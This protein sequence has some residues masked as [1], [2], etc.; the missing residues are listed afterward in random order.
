MAEVP[1]PTLPPKN[2]KFWELISIPVAWV[3][4]PPNLTSYPDNV[5]PL[6]AVVDSPVTVAGQA[7]LQSVPKHNDPP[8]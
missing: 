5:R 2:P 8:V 6:E 7:V 3:S 1:I 4:L